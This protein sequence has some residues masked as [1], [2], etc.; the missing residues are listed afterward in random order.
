MLSLTAA[1]TTKILTHYMPWYQAPPIENYWGWHWTMNY[2]NPDIIKQNGLRSIA[3]KYYPLTGPYDSRDIDILEYHVL[4]M[5]LSGIDGVIVDWYGIKDYND[6]SVLHESTQNLFSYIQDAGLKFSICY[7][8]QTIKNMVDDGYFTPTEALN[9]G[10]EVMEYMQ[11]NWFK[12]D[13]YVRINNQPLLLSWGPTYFK[14]NSDWESMFSSLNP[15]PMLFTLDNK[16]FASATGAYP[17]PPMHLSKNGILN[18]IDLNLYLAQFYQK[19]LAWDHLVATAFPGFND[20]YEQAG[21]HDSYGFLDPADGETFRSTLSTAM[22]YNPNILQITTWND[23]GEGTIIEPTVEFGFT[24]LEEIQKLRKEKIDS[25]FNYDLD[26]LELAFSIYQLRKEHED[27]YDIH[28]QL[29][30]AYYHIING[31]IDEAKAIVNSL[32]PNSI[33]SGKNIIEQ[34][35]ISEAYPNPFNPSTQIKLNIP[36]NY[37]FHISVYDINGNLLEKGTSHYFLQ[38]KNYYKW[39][40]N[41]LSSGV[42]FIHFYNSDFQQIRKVVLLK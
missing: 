34:F 4:L 36:Q 17:W 3:S 15:K 18:S 7:E 35:Q 41:N 38:G 6:Y 12:D 40:P 9:H 11:N 1:E 37:N 32:L 24:Y 14:S 33:D 13:C 39:T 26:E 29:D 23:Y 8:D 19:S 25:T 20:I 5:K 2:F 28:N 10:S 16:L 30:D 42:Y 22:N 21:L 31:E 27:E